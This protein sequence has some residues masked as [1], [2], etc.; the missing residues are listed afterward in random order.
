MVIGKKKTCW[1]SDVKSN[2]PKTTCKYC[3]HYNKMRPYTP[4][5]LIGFL[6][7]SMVPEQDLVGMQ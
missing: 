2:K 7:T 5:D 3:F 6:V 4:S 1:S